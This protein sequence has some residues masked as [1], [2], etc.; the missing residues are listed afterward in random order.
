MQLFKPYDTAAKQATKGKN[1]ASDKG[2]DTHAA[3][4]SGGASSRSART[5]AEA[6]TTAPS[7]AASALGHTNVSTKAKPTTSH[8]STS[9]TATTTSGNRTHPDAPKAPTKKMI[10]TPTRREAEQ[11][12]RDRIQPVLTRKESKAR[13]REARFKARDDAMAKAN[14]RPHNELI[15]DWVD[16]RWNLA[17]FALPLILVLF[18]AMIIGTYI[19]PVLMFIAPYAIWGVFLLLVID[20]LVMWFGLRKQLKTYFPNEPLKGKLSYAVSRTMLMR[21]S[22]VPAPRLKRGQKFTWPHREEQA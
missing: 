20:T 5:S 3:K 6:S 12:R 14:A 8:A 10:P 9:A 13:E 19:W 7:K 1:S 18:V 21:R 2:G 16:R 22:R 4:K 15:R 17:E 11:A